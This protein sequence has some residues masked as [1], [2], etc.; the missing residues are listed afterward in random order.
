MIG[1]FPCAHNELHPIV[2]R[3]DVVDL[4]P[5]IR[6][7]PRTRIHKTLAVEHGPKD[8]FEKANPPIFL[9][10]VKLFERKSIVGVKELDLEFLARA[11][12]EAQKALSALLGLHN[13]AELGGQR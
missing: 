4:S 6:T 12:G 8:H 13:Q 2:H 7:D 1:M 9:D 5:S 10:P 11:D 3:W